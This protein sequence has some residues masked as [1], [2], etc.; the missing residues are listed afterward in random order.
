MTERDDRA[1]RPLP[2]R[3]V[4][5]TNAYHSKY[6]IIEKLDSRLLCGVCGVVLPR[7]RRHSLSCSSRLYRAIPVSFLFSYYFIK[8]NY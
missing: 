2:L 8:L 6:N 4:G 7:H 3:R 5:K 1:N